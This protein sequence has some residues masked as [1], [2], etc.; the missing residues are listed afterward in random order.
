MSILIRHTHKKIKCNFLVLFYL[1]RNKEKVKTN[2]YIRSEII[3][4]IQKTTQ[5]FKDEIVH[6]WKDGSDWTRERKKKNVINCSVDSSCYWKEN[7]ILADF[8][9]CPY[10]YTQPRTHTHARAFTHT[11]LEISKKKKTWRH[12]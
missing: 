10:T 3:S 1:Q 5:L 12:T 2:R 6:I 4:F 9:C 8:S 7:M 11:H